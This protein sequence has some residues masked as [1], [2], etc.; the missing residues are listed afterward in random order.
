MIVVYPGLSLSDHPGQTTTS[1][2]LRVSIESTIGI[3][4]T[5][6]AFGEG[7]TQHSNLMMHKSS[8]CQL[9]PD[10]SYVP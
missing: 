10:T 6:L 3:Y 2:D 7:N 9:S 1:L 4:F 5:Y 8:V